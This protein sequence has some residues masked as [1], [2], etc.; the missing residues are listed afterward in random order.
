MGKNEELK[1]NI[2]DLK[3]CQAVQENF[4]KLKTWVEYCKEPIKRNLDQ[5]SPFQSTFRS[6]EID[7]NHYTNSNE[8]PEIQR[9]L[10]ILI[11]KIIQNY[12]RQIETL[13]KEK[14]NLATKQALEPQINAIVLRKNQNL[15]TKNYRYKTKNR[16]TDV[17]GETVYHREIIPHNYFQDGNYY[18]PWE[19][20]PYWLFRIWWLIAPI[21]SWTKKNLKRIWR[22]FNLFWKL[23]FSIVGFLGSSIAIALL[24]FTTEELKS[25]ILE[26]WHRFL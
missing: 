16:N 18:T 24:F 12:S 23:I 17:T 20:K 22:G 2:A 11:Q 25:Y 7:V 13:E 19:Y 10:N 8:L 26:L 4:D 15:L 5:I 14:V 1:Q 6:I 3:G 21:I 9:R